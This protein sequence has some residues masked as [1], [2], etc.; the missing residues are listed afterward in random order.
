TLRVDSTRW[1]AHVR[2]TA[3]EHGDVIAVVKGNGYGFG[4]PRLAA[5][6]LELG[7]DSLAVGTVHEVASLPADAVAPIVLTPSID[8][9]RLPRSD[10]TLTVGSVPHLD[11][12]PDGTA[13]IVKLASSMH[14][15]GA[16]PDALN[17]LLAAVGRR[18]LALRGFALHLPL[19]ADA[20]EVD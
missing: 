7:L 18:R 15:Y 1:R 13:V 8:G 11:A 19:D 2:R 6:A 20:T 5:V 17:E 10:V 4:I 12:V 14:R 16:T 9:T 3:D